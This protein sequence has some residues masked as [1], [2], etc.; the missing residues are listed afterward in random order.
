MIVSGAGFA[1]GGFA[2][3]AHRGG[4]RPVGPVQIKALGRKRELKVQQTET[5]ELP[6]RGSERKGAGCPLG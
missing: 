4:W 6:I 3:E 1:F 2:I 5:G